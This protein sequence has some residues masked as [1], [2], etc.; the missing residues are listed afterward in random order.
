MDK[1]IL[2]I[3]CTEILAQLGGNKFKVMTGAKDIN[4]SSSKD[5]PNLSFRLPV[6]FAQRGI[7]VVS[8]VLNVMDLYDIEFIKGTNPSAANGYMGKRVVVESLSGIYGDTLA[9]VFTEVTGLDVSL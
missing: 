8:I 5:T 7:N 3:Q 1:D 4:Y 6:R 2:R 9:S